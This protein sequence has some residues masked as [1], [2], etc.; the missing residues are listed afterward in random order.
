MKQQ[1][2]HHRDASASL[3][4]QGRT[5]IQG[6]RGLARKA[7]LVAGTAAVSFPVAG[8]ASTLLSLGPAAGGV[9]G[10]G[11]AAGGWGDGGGDGG[12]FGGGGSDSLFSLAPASASAQEEEEEEEDSDAAD[13]QEEFV[14]EGVK[15]VNLPQGPGIP[16][17]SELFEGLNCRKGATCTRKGLSDDLNALLSTGLFQNVDANVQ[18]STKGYIVEFVFKEK[19]WPKMESFKVTGAT[20]LPTSIADDVLRE[21]Q[22]SENVTVRTLAAAKNIVEGYYQD[23][24]ITFGTI[25]HFDGMET[26]NV[27][28][29]VIE[30]QITKV[31]L[32]FVDDK[33]NEVGT[34]TTKP[35]IVYGELPIK[36]GQLYNLEEA[37]RGLQDISTLQLFDNVQIQPKPD[38]D[39]PSK[40]AL[41]VVLKERPVRTAEMELE[42]GIAPGPKGKPDLTSLTPGGNAYIE[43]RNLDGEG[44]SLSASL[45][46][47]NFLAPQDD[48][49]FRVEYT[50]PRVFGDDDENR[51]R[52][53]AAAFNS[54]KASPAYSGGPTMDEVPGV[55]ID[56][57]GGK[58][59]LTENLTR[60]SRC[61]YG[62]VLQEITARDESGGVCVNGSKTLPNGDSVSDGPPTTWS[63]DGTDRVASA[64][65]SFTRDN[66]RFVNGATVGPRD[67]AHVDQ[68]LGFG[69][70]SPLNNRHSLSCT[71]FLKLADPPKRSEMPP[72][73]LVMHG[74]VSNAIGDLPTYD[75]YTLGGPNSC[76]GYG[77][78]ELGVSRRSVETAVEARVPVPKANCH[79]FA[80]YEHVND[81]GGSKE[82][83]GN[84]TAYYR[85][86]GA[87]STYGGGLRVGPIRAEWCMDCN[88]CKGAWFLRFG[89]RY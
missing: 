86:A 27:V 37:K 82:V 43:H 35:K 72:P 83:S 32:V 71:R 65:A 21:A 41:D 29:H 51:T 44:T 11:G 67:I 48:L 77:V 14:C 80:F 42:W 4:C 18:P 64:Q 79:A 66:T 78:G 16:T 1:H 5:R 38:E 9:A 49:G 69:P 57:S 54:R 8:F 81:L 58:A 50:V 88:R 17:Q 13:D 7:A 10:A 24:G 62:L 55:W 34:S 60:Q 19:V 22:K 23:R 31:N 61:S 89:E 45:S 85:R 56:R 36:A 59:S 46:T 15:A 25:K 26:G 53:K 75:A 84:P 39:E 63:A 68:T 74:K 2:S 47:T 28:A 6:T 33:G 3:N 30:G 20:I 12:G 73:V 52:F 40:V 87:G 70:T 76:R